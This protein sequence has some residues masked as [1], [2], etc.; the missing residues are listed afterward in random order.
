MSEREKYFAY[1]RK[2]IGKKF[3]YMRKKMYLCT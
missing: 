2:I 3:A 1:M